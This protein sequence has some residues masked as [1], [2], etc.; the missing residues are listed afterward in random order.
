MSPI[1]KAKIA[2]K[3]VLLVIDSAEELDF[4]QVKARIPELNDER[5]ILIQF[6]LLGSGC[7]FDGL[8]PDGDWGLRSVAS[9]NELYR[10][11]NL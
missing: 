6:V 3:S 7:A 5:K 4:E 8:I 1:D 11:V 2:Y 9:L 10:V